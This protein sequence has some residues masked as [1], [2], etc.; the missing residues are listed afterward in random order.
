M[1]SNLRQGCS[2][3]HSA[4]SSHNPHEQLAYDDEVDDMLQKAQETVAQRAHLMHHE[5]EENLRTGDPEC[6]NIGILP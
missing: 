3:T 4:V 5:E 6:P 1:S 2:L